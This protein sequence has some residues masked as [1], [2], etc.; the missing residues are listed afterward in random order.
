MIAATATVCTAPSDP[1]PA[2]EPLPPEHYGHV[3]T[4]AL[5]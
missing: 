3:T 4:V 5:A 2:A 1:V